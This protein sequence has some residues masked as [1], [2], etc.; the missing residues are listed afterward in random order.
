MSSVVTPSSPKPYKPTKHVVQIDPRWWSL[1][2]VDGFNAR[3]P[4]GGVTDQF[5]YFSGRVEGE[6]A[7][8]Q[9]RTA[10]DVGPQD[11]VVRQL[12]QATRVKAQITTRCRG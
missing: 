4:Q 8:E 7:G 12:L 11:A 2:V 10:G 5:S 3:P 6:A 1:G 9:G